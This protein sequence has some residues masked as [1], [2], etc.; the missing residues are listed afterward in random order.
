MVL[1]LELQRRDSDA[2]VVNDGLRGSRPPAGQMLPNLAAVPGTTPPFPAAE[3]LEGTAVALVATCLQ[4]RSGDIIGGF[5]GRLQPGRIP[6]GATVRVVGW[7]D[8]EAWRTQWAIPEEFVVHEVAPRGVE[9]ARRRLGIG[10]VGDA[11]ES[12]VTYLYDTSGRWRS[13][14]FIGQ[15]D[16]NGVVHDLELL[17]TP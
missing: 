4:C 9:L 5:L 14:W 17:S 7:G 16:A 2:N 13:S 3:K 15:L 10:P 6:D 11:E 1:Y 8:S 12:G